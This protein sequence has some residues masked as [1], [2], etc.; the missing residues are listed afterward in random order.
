MRIL[1]IRSTA[2]GRALD[3]RY[4]VIDPDKARALFDPKVEPVLIHEATGSQFG[5][6]RSAKVGPLRNTRKSGIEKGKT[7]FILFANPG[8]LVKSGDKVTIKVGDFRIDDLAV[9]Q[10]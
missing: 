9:D 7:Y 10:S 8:G 6:P 1:S 5:V 4:K 2:A 3:F